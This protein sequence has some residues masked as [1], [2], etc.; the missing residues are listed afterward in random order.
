M[1]RGSAFTLMLV[2]A[3]TIIGAYLR[4]ATLR[5]QSLWLDEIGQAV[6]ARQALPA[7]GRRLAAHRPIAIAGAD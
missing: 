5:S 4:L 7:L 1:D 2:V 6:T 3:V